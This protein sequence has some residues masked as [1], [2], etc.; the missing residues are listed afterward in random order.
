MRILS[1]II[2]SFFSLI[3]KS[4]NHW[5]VD[6]IMARDGQKLAADVYVPDTSGGQTYP[7]ILIQTPYNRQF[8]RINLP[9]GFG[10]QTQNM[11]FAFVTLDWRCFYGSLGAC[12][13]G[14]DRGKDGYD[15]VEWIATQAWSNGKIGTWG[16][17]AL[18]R[19]QYLTAKEKP[20]HLTCAVPLVAGP[21][22]NYQEYY[23]GGVLREEYV[24][25]L[26][27]LALGSHPLYWLI[28]LMIYSGSI[29]K[30]AAFIHP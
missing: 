4:Q 5:Y 16:P 8:Y 17:S 30:A 13:V 15:V 21:Q 7:T 6:S 24:E 2:I 9:L 23:P 1:V 3:L 29:L 22:Y 20:P 26:D 19:I 18:G 27:A 28:R 25:T 12:T 14:L 10:T 11:P